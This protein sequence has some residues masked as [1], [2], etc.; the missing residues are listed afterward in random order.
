MAM[1]STNGTSNDALDARRWQKRT[2]EKVSRP[3]LRHC[4]AVDEVVDMAQAQRRA[5]AALQPVQDERSTGEAAK[6]TGGSR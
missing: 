2:S 5:E 6:K 3:L 1:K 4:E